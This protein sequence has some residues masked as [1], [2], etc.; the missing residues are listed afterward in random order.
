MVLFLLVWSPSGLVRSASAPLDAHSSVQQPEGRPGSRQPFN[1]R[2][3]LSAA[4]WS[5]PRALRRPA[6]SA[7]FVG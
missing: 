5:S 7:P 3:C 1:V 2:S 6:R 4:A